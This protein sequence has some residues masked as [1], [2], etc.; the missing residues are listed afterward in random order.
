M[1]LPYKNLLWCDRESL[2]CIRAVLIHQSATQPPPEVEDFDARMNGPD[3]GLVNAWL[4]GRALRAP[5]PGLAA[6]AVAGELPVLPYRGGVD[7]TIKSTKKLGSLLYVAMWQG[8]RG[9]D[10]AV[11]S[12][13]E[14]RLR[15]ARYDVEVTFTPD[16]SLFFGEGV[17]A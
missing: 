8:L 11:D 7:R 3:G 4:A 15:C 17:E 6:A 16:W 5:Q 14:I 10:L 13:Q 2:C 1:A 9:D 12:A